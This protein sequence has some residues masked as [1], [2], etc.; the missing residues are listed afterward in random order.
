MSK[1]DD[2]S[3]SELQCNEK[4]RKKGLMVKRVLHMAAAIQA[5]IVLIY[6]YFHLMQRFA[7][8]GQKKCK[9][10]ALISSNLRTIRACAVLIF[11]ATSS[12]LVVCWQMKWVFLRPCDYVRMQFQQLL[13]RVDT[14]ILTK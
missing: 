2:S 8:Y 3:C 1:M 4:K 5:K 9:K 7:I 10:C 11:L 13:N 6:F 14:S 12:M